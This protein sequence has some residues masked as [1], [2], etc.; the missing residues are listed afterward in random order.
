MKIYLLLIIIY[1]NSYEY[2]VKNNRNNYSFNFNDSNKYVNVIIDNNYRN[3]NIENINKQLLA[4]INGSI[5]GDS[6]D[7]SYDSG[8]NI[9][10]NKDEKINNGN[11]K[12]QMKG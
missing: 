4:E 3:I 5:E 7:K 1:I 6:K 11:F 2:S 12:K 9:N 10:K 8:N